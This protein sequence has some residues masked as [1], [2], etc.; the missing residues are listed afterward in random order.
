MR[1][2]AEDLRQLGVI[3]RVVP[4][5][6]GGAHRDPVET[7]RTLGRAIGEE[8]DRYSGMPGSDVRRQRRQKF[9]AIG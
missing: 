3:E 2:T 7:V 9:M 4:E 8:L 5:P 1:V 6:V